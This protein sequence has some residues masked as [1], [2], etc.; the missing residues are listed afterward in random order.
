M[1]LYQQ[2]L[3]ELQDQAAAIRQSGPVAQSGYRIDTS[4]SRGNVYARLRTVSH[5]RGLGRVGSAEHRDWQQ[6]IRRREA[7]AE[8]EDRAL[9][10]RSWQD[11]PVWLAE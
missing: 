2:I 5:S 9:T 10:V 4:T 3:A 11:T 7:L 8:I 6:R 1:S